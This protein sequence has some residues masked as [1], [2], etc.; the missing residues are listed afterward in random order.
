MPAGRLEKSL[1]STEDEGL[2]AAST[3]TLVDWWRRWIMEA[4]NNGRNIIPLNA[5]YAMDTS[6]ETVKGSW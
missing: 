4:S 2:A 5:Y 3:A 1:A 6:R